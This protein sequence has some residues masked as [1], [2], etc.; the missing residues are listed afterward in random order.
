MFCE[1]CGKTVAPG[2]RFCNNCGAPVATP[3]VASGGVSSAAATDSNAGKRLI[4]KIL[5]VV[6]LV[7]FFLP[8]VTVSC[9]GS[10]VEATGFEGA[11]GMFDDQLSDQTDA[12]MNVFL[13]ISMAATIG[14]LILSVAKKGTDQKAVMALAGV[15]AISGL[16]FMITFNG[17]YEIEKEDLEYITV[18]FK[19]GY[20]GM[21]LTNAGAAIVAAM[22]KPDSSSTGIGGRPISATFA[23]KAPTPPPAAPTYTPPAPPAYTP[24]TPAPEAPVYTPPAPTPAAPS[25]PTGGNGLRPPE[26]L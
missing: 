8:F 21:L 5:L 24:P 23:P 2:E 16:L 4:V 1:K 17:Y 3:A 25:A 15:A 9:G 7:C 13:I 22:V 14:G 19:L 11:F 20:W 6:A 12:K 26:D 18:E 10:E